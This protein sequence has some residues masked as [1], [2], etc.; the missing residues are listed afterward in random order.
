MPFRTSDLLESSCSFRN[1][2]S[3]GDIFKFANTTHLD[4]RHFSVAKENQKKQPTF[5]LSL[6]KRDFIKLTWRL[7]EGL[8]H[9]PVSAMG[10]RVGAI[11]GVGKPSDRRRGFPSKEGG[12]SLVETG[13]EQLR[14]L[15][16]FC[17]PT[18]QVAQLCSFERRLSSQATRQ[19]LPRHMDR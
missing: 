10:N 1:G 18:S 13:R 2:W 11:L 3:R 16:C 14:W 5:P 19:P 9:L 17:S 7:V 6:S 4:V 12:L 15:P 8:A